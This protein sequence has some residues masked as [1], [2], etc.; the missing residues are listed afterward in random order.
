VGEDVTF[1]LGLIEHFGCHVWGI[2]PTPRAAGYVRKMVPDE[3]RYHFVPEGL[4]STTGVQ[5]FYAPVNPSHVSHSIVNLRQTDSY[6][7]AQCR[8]LSDLMHENGHDHLDLLKL[9]IEGAEFEVM[10]TLHE[11]GVFPAIVAVEFDQ[12]ASLASIA[13]ASQQMKASGYQLVSIDRWNYTF[14]RG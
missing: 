7:E 1:D 11:D 3:G 4:W 2:D 13:E 14:V 5:R 9:D 12:P 10:Q 8:R 6:F